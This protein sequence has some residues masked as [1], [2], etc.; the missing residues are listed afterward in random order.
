MCFEPESPSLA[1]SLVVDIAD[2]WPRTIDGS[3]D[4]AVADIA[5]PWLC[6]RVGLMQ[7]LRLRED[8]HESTCFQVVLH[9]QTPLVQE[10]WKGHADK[11]NR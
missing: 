9:V 3:I 2:F 10:K 1:T 7:R 5:W 4:C 8:G 6:S 11:V